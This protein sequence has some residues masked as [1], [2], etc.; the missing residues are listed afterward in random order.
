I[1]AEGVED[2]AL[3][4]A[5]PRSLY[6]QRKLKN[7]SEFIAWARSQGFK[8]VTDA[9]EL[10][11]T[12]LYSRAAVDGMKMGETWDQNE[13][14]EITVQPGGARIVEPLGDK[15]AIVLLF[16]SSELSWRHRNMI[17][18]GASHDYDD[19]QPHVTITYNGEG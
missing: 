10:H 17:E 1:E 9:D 16:N 2:V 13:K 12:V 14:G 4:D 7:T 8:S 15:G 6:V 3:S 18:L 5:L 19:Y 11:V